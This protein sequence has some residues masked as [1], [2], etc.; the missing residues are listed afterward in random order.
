M[1][2]LWCIHLKSRKCYD[3]PYQASGFIPRSGAVCM[4]TD[5]FRLSTRRGGRMAGS[6]DAG[7]EGWF[8]WQCIARCRARIQEGWIEWWWIVHRRGS[9]VF[10]LLR[11]IGALMIGETKNAQAEAQAF[12]LL[13]KF[14]VLL[15]I[16]G[17][18]WHLLLRH[19]VHI[20]C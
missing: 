3:R 10:P 15:A 19:V 6:F 11:A 8:C 17:R 4:S 20:C 2:F 13:R 1:L 7:Y 12:V 16:Q 18:H 9:L 14:V 5:G